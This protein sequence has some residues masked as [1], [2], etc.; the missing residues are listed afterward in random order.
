MLHEIGKIY[1]IQYLAT[2]HDIWGREESEWLNYYK[3][4]FF[5]TKEAALEEMESIRDKDEDKEL[6]YVEVN[7]WDVKE[8]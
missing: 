7:L 4:D 6:R 2:G 1:K 5:N 8:E 3:E